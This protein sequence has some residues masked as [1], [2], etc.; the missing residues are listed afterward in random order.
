M[1]VAVKLR[2]RILNMAINDT[3]IDERVKTILSRKPVRF[4][5]ELAGS[6]EKELRLLR[7]CGHGVIS[8][9]RKFLAE[10]KLSLKDSQLYDGEDLR[11]IGLGPAITNRVKAAGIDSTTKLVQAY[12]NGELDPVFRRFE[13]QLDTVRNRL[14]KIGR[15]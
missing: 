1:S 11:D 13:D 12:R 14:I 6:T 10:Y 3:N 7:G 8:D 15:I 5:Y 4:V 9:I 2:L